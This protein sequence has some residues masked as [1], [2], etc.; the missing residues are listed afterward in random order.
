[1]LNEKEIE[2]IEKFCNDEVM[3]E[4]VKKVLLAGIYE[5]GTIKE[6]M[7][8]LPLKN[9][10]LADAMDPTNDPEMVG[11]ALQVSASGISLV[12]NCWARLQDYKVPVG[13]KKVRAPNK[14]L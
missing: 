3:F 14:A 8:A 4:A 9:F 5:N 12:E 2:K 7:P 11:R 10:A 13:K 6:G 1:M